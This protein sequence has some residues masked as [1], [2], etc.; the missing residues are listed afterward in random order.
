VSTPWEKRG[1]E[2]HGWHI[3]DPRATDAVVAFG[4]YLL[5]LVDGLRVQRWLKNNRRA[6]VS[7]AA[8]TDAPVR[9]TA[10]CNGH[11]WLRYPRR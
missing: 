2:L 4:I 5:G 11:R 7:K 8:L 3:G 9:P 6:N 10:H 1:Q